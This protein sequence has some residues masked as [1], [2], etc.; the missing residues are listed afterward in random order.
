MTLL[1]NVY[2]AILLFVVTIIIYVFGVIL[3][4]RK[5]R[6]YF[7]FA[8]SLTCAPLL[9]TKFSFLNMYLKANVLGTLGL[10]FYTLKALSYIIDI[11]R[12]KLK[13]EKHFG[14]YALYIA[15]VPQLFAGPID[16]P[17][18]L[19]PQ[20]KNP[21]ALTAGRTY[22]G[23]IRVLWG[24]FQKIVV[25]D[26]VAIVVNNIYLQ[27]QNYIGLPLILAMVLFSVQIYADFSGYSNIAIGAARM[28]G[29][30]S[31][32]NFNRPY[33]AKSL[34]DFW[35]RWH[36]SLSSW[37]RDY[38]YI[39]LGGNR[40]NFDRQ[41]INI[42]IT[43]L[44]SG[45]WHGNGV[46]FVAWGLLHGLVLILSNLLKSTSSVTASDRDW[47]QLWKYFAKIYN[48]LAVPITFSLVTVLWVFFRAPSLNDALYIVSHFYRGLGSVLKLLAAFK[49]E[50]FWHLL[51]S[52]GYGISE[53]IFI[54]TLFTVALFIILSFFIGNIQNQHLHDRSPLQRWTFYYVVV[55][56]ILFS[57]LFYNT[58]SVKFIYT[59]F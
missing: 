52:D 36:I 18:T 22:E 50:D 49:F 48:F 8:V 44:A 16:R 37:L 10:S 59:R 38:I 5:N 31:T 6:V 43:F 40:V 33:L 15:F 19:I 55:F 3:E 54:S 51:Y 30:N 11:Y 28:L 26:R 39:P 2:A 24:L 34:Q 20:L 42:L 25:A 1:I 41:S 29:I 9:L 47:N 46:T 21:V 17:S 56:M 27:P 13:P 14:Y 12:N 57:M 23:L 58:Q 35:T 32:E 53:D 7:F 45:F 4:N